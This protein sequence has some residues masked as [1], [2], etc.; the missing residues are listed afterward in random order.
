MPSEQEM[1]EQMQMQ[2]QMQ[3]QEE[4]QRMAEEQQRMEIE[5]QRQALVQ[6]LNQ[7]IAME[8][9]FW[10]TFDES[11]EKAF[12]DCTIDEI[13]STPTYKLA[14]LETMMKLLHQGVQIPPQIWRKYLDL[15]QDVM[16]EWNMAEEQQRQ[17]AIAMQQGQMQFEMQKEQIKAEVKLQLQQLINKGMVDQQL[18]QQQGKSAM[19]EQ[20]R[21]YQVSDK[22]REE[23]KG[24]MNE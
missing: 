3:A 8:E 1:A 6:Q 10:N 13:Q 17:E 20:K 23:E 7:A 18:V 11:R 14:T 4:E 9:E 21:D 15:E 5:Q 19:E 22:V 16:D 24:A 12:Y 2:E